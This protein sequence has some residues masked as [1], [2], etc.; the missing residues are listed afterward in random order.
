MYKRILV[1]LD[2]SELAEQMLPY[3]RIIGKRLQAQ[4]ELLQVFDPVSPSLADPSHGL[5]LDQIATS[6]R[7]QT[8]DYL[9]GVALSLRSDGLKVSSI[10]HE[11]NPASHIVSE[12]ERE[13]ATLIA[14]STHGRS[15]ISRWMLGSITDKVL[16]ATTTP[17]LI[18]RP[19]Q[20]NLPSETKLNTIVV[21][22][23]GSG[24][25][26][27]VLPH[28]VALAKLLEL[29][30]TLIMVTPS[31]TDYYQYA[32]NLA[33]TYR[34]LFAKGSADALDYLLGIKHR[35]QQEGIRTVEEQLLQ[36]DPAAAIVDHARE[37]R[38]NFVAMT[39]HGR[40]GV[41]RWFL[42]SVADRVVRYSGDPVLVIRAKKE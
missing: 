34:D 1:P 38:D 28:V 12:A 18:I 23:D 20:Q 31:E 35:L 3:A 39:T 8:Q 6:F 40:S 19:Q 33:A 16:Y 15:G 30:V 22:L 21:P 27:Q 29:K 42:G 41:G 32:E 36:G 13:P 26:E 24:L 10:V 5:Y 4:V 11:G 37:V 9:E 25:A 14:M 7:N 17:L 2:G